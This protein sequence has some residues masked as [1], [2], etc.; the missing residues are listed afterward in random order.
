[1]Q[2]SLLRCR[3]DSNVVHLLAACRRRPPQTRAHPAVAN[4]RGLVL[5]LA[6]VFTPERLA[7]YIPAI[8][9]VRRTTSNVLS[10]AITWP[11]SF[12]LLLAMTRRPASVLSRF[13]S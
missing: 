11:E 5:I 3:R 9:A 1:M 7:G 13:T 4:T 2:P 6:C 10:S 8:L 12:F